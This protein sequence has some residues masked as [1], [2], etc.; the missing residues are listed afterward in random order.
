M[1]FSQERSSAQGVRLHGSV[2]CSLL[3]E[4]S[5]EREALVGVAEVQ[6]QRRVTLNTSIL[7]LY[8]VTSDI[9]ND[10]QYLGDNTYVLECSLAML[11]MSR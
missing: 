1:S 11:G 4:E 7:K 6:W 2:C 9:Q 3:R 8:I 5:H 10:E